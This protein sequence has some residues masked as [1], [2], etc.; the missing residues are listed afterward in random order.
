MLLRLIVVTFSM[1]AAVSAVGL[2]PLTAQELASA[3][4][5][6][7]VT[8]PSPG[9][10][11]AALNKEAKPNWQTQ[12]RPP[13][14]TT[15]PSRIQI[16]LNVGSLIADGY[17]AVEAEDSQQV[18]NIGKDIIA[19]AKSL[20]V[21]ESVIARGSSIV[22]FAE[23]NEWNSLKEEMEA[24]Q[25]EV[26][27]ALLEQN[28]S[29]LVSLVSLGGWIRGVS[30]VSGWIAGNYTPGSAK[31]L[32][33]P[34]VVALMRAKINELPEKMQADPLIKSI[35]RQLAD[36]E[37]LVSFSSDTVPT[38]DDV[39]KLRELSIALVQEISK[40]NEQK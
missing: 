39:K 1:A 23:K 30:V 5:V 34:A 19:L 15:F 4:K 3:A 40:K 29:E 26:K 7:A 37:K 18:K 8:I 9:E 16:A 17:I 31:L 27:L 25:N 11:M 24:T 22:D 2:A 10:L 21:S 35:A 33:Q 13:I 12:Y 36:I 14:P 38:Q 28:D 20:A 32:R 6:D